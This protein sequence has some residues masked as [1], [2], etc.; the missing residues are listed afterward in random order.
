MKMFMDP[1][2]RRLRS[3]I[4]QGFHKR[5]KNQYCEQRHWLK[6]SHT[7]ILRENGDCPKENPAMEAKQKNIPLG[8]EKYETDTN[9]G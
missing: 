5:S 3:S 7:S 2:R 1:N 4:N 8:Q 9:K 6:V